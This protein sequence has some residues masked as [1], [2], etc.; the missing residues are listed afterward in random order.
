[1]AKFKSSNRRASKGKAPFGVGTIDQ[2]L[3][4]IL[5]TRHWFVRLFGLAGK[6]VIFD[7]VH[8]YD[9]YMSTILERLLQWLAELDCTVILLSATLPEAKRKALIN[10]YSGRNDVENKE[11]PRI[12]LAGP[13]HYLSGQADQ[14]PVCEE[15]TIG[16]TSYVNLHFAKTYLESLT[17]YLAQR[18]E[19]GGCAAI[20]CN[21]VDRSIE[22]YRH[23]RDNLNETEC[24]LF[25]A[26]TLQM[27]RS[28]RE[29]EVLRKFGKGAK[30]PDG[31]YTN[32]SRPVRA[33][34][35]ATQVIEQS[36]DLD[37]DLMVSEIAPVDLLLQRLGR[38]HRH[39][40]SRPKGLEMPEFVVLCDAQR[41]GLPPETF[42]KSIEHVYDR[43]FLLRTWLAV[44]EK[45][46][47]QIPTEIEELVEAVYGPDD[48]TQD[49][50]WS[51]ALECAKKN[52][53]FE[54][55]ESEKAASQLLVSRPGDPADIVQKFNSELMDDEDPEVHKAV[56]AA[57]RE[58][59][60]AVTVIM[61]DVSTL[62]NQEPTIAEVRD[63][64]NRSVKLSHR[65][66][67]HALVADGVKPKEWARNAHLRHARLLRLNERN[68]SRVDGFIL[69]VD[70]KLGIVIEK[71][72]EDDG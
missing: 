71:E 9:A 35:V 37:F 15:V 4:S 19:H 38:L 24:S 20:I 67:Y 46:K 59:D 32:P 1:M 22:V 57:T 62:L 63:L 5:Q 28:Q 52:M 23:L 2:S 47:I 39:S 11:Y 41:E 51:E 30:Q 31:T 54:Q 7:E 13:R 29:E 53:E 65:G 64:L 70:E 44:R 25:H 16:S 60:P 40:R 42:S 68:Q 21:T 14:A 58:G 10:A 43:Y 27:W 56:R 61:V 36:M 3:L 6:V 18:L 55:S 69:T 48:V 8:A 12:T 34:L 72:S 49:V 45:D 66:V 50:G 33:V 17:T 26:R